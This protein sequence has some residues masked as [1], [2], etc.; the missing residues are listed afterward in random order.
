M[1]KWLRKIKEG[2]GIPSWKAIVHVVVVQIAVQL[3]WHFVSKGFETPLVREVGFLVIFCVA[4]IAV[5]LYLPKLPRTLTGGHPSKKSDESLE[6][7]Q[8]LASSD[9]Q[10]LPE[11]V[12]ARIN[13]W[14]FRGIGKPEPYFEI[15]IELINATLFTLHLVGASGFIV[16]DGNRCNSPPQVSE[17]WSIKHG[18]RVFIR[19][20]Q[21]I[22]SRTANRITSASN[23]GETVKFDLREFQLNL[24]TTDVGYEGNKIL[25]RGKEEDIITRENSQPL[26]MF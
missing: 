10:R 14:Y 16:I 2:L 12:K 13:H 5:A 11:F 15:S 4:L 24:E 26:I 6:W 7:L 20:Y 17:Q 9:L 25:V 19:V 21:P 23:N 3:I 8:T 1:R 22:T 18:D